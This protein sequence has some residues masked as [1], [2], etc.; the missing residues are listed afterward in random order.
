[1][2]EQPARLSVIALLLLAFL[3]GGC[4]SPDGPPLMMATPAAQSVSETPGQDQ[5]ADADGS[6]TGK[7]LAQADASTA[8]ALSTPELIDK[9]YADGE[10]DEEER[11]LYLT[12]AVY[13]YDS[14]PAAYQSDVGW[15]GTL[16]VRELD[17]FLQSPAFCD[18]SPDA[19]AE[20]ERLLGEPS[21][22]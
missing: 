19:Q 15:R 2:I 1:M 22:K 18:I 13:S 20:L 4:I 8:E 3:L 11:I 6:E 21:C 10:I 9:A 5:S 16:L 12:Y 7:A 14:L 17:E